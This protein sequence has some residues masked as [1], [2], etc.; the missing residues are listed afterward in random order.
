MKYGHKH[1]KDIPIYI[2]VTTARLK[3][4]THNTGINN[5]HNKNNYYS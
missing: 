4:Q 1:L 3:G 5:T 2:W